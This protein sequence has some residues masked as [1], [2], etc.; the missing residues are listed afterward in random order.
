ME[1]TG[2]DAVFVALIVGIVQQ[3]KTLPVF[4]AKPKRKLRIKGLT[5]LVAAVLA[6]LYTYLEY[7]GT[8]I[9]AFLAQWAERAIV[10]WV[11]AMGTFDGLKTVNDAKETEEADGDDESG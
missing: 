6:V 7:E 4:A 11:A 2:Q 5:A 1:L 8:G 9:G 3:L 10:G